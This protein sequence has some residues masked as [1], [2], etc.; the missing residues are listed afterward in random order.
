MRF[1]NNRLREKHINFDEKTQGKIFGN[2]QNSDRKIDVENSAQTLCPETLNFN[3]FYL[4]H[5]FQDLK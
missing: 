3:K 5:H 4:F 1:T 2:R